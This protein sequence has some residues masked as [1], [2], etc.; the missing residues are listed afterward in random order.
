MTPSKRSYLIYADGSC[1]GNPGPGGW[2]VVVREPNG[3]VREYNGTATSTTT[4][5]RMEITAAIEGLRATEPGA[6]VVLRSDSLYVVNTMNLGWKRKANQDLWELLDA[7]AKI[8]DVKFEWVRG[9]GV[10]PLNNRAD[11]LAVMGAKRRRVAD[12]LPPQP[13]PRGQSAWDQIVENAA[14]QLKPLLKP[15][16]R[17]IECIG[18]AELFVSRGDDERFCPH[19]R[20]QWKARRS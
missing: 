3:V 20:C 7:E 13:L 17:I 1:L 6:D 2:G 9:H 19:V 14:E 18:C 16:E 4:N 5:Q 15:G 12:Q 8:R 10:D 11:E